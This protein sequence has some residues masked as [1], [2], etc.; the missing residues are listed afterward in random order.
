MYPRYVICDIEATGLHAEKEPIE[1]ALITLQDDKIVDVYETL[2]DP[3]LL[4]S[5]YIKDFTSIS[6]KELSVA[7]KF[8]EV[9]D[10]IRLRLEGAIF[11]SHNTDFDLNLLKKKYEQMGQELK[12]KSFCT[13]KVAQYEIPG[14]KSYTL[15]AL[16]SFFNIKI[17]QRHRALGDAKSTLELFKQLQQLNLKANHYARFLP[18]HEKYLKAIPA[19]AGLLQFRE[20]SG[21]VIRFESSFNMQR[22]AR[23][24]MEVR[25]GNRQ[26][27][28]QVESIKAE[29]TGSALIAEFRKLL[30]HPFRPRWMITAQEFEGQKCFK[31]KPYKKELAGLWFFEDYTAAQK[32]LKSLKVQLKGESFIYREGG[33]SKEEVVK[34]NQKVDLLSKEAKFPHDDLIFLGEGRSLGEKSVILV[35]DGHVIGHG[36]TTAADEDIYENPE[37]HLSRRFFHHPGADVA[38]K[39]HLRVLKNVKNKNEGW[40]SLARHAKLSGITGEKR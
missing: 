29:V 20:E 40:R 2:I 17:K 13:L 19:K 27:L 3:M 37:R 34:H 10:T 5:E 23:T 6:Q 25:P 32:K 11:V 30:F 4:V 28:I 21:K 15:D 38:A 18:H 14:L 7:P 36:Y 39:Q 33:K 22:T 31:V 26:L 16:C 35:R 8:Y 12:L 9:A 24:L 1:I